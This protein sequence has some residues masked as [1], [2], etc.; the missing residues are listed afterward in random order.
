MPTKFEV[1]CLAVV[2]APACELPVIT[3]AVPGAGDLIEH[4]ING[5]VQHEPS[6]RG[7]V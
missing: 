3:T 2:E 7:S 5:L 6:S 4:G 1:F